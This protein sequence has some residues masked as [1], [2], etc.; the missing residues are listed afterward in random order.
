MREPSPA[1]LAA[2]VALG[3]I[4]GSD[5]DFVREFGNIILTQVSNADVR[6]A[7]QFV[8]ERDGGDQFIARVVKNLRRYAGQR[9]PHLKIALDELIKASEEPEN[10]I[11]ASTIRIR[12]RRSA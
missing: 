5:D 3:A 6:R 10:F 11:R 12:G 1:V 4:G 8:L 2:L 7:L 9:P